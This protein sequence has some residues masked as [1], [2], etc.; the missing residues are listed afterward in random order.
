M[1]EKN[2]KY[3][4]KIKLKKKK[5]SITYKT[6]DSHIHT[7]LKNDENAM[8][9]MKTDLKSLRKYYLIVLGILAI[10]FSVFNASSSIVSDSFE[11]NGVYMIRVFTERYFRIGFKSDSNSLCHKSQSDTSM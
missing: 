1:R 7:T 3:I 10:A 5:K 11:L 9:T 6:K 8:K 4:T 2:I